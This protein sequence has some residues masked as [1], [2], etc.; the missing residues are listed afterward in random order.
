MVTSLGGQS[1]TTTQP[2]ANGATTTTTVA[3]TQ[4]GDGSTTQTTTTTTS[5]TGDVLA[6]ADVRS[7]PK[8]AKE[9]PFLY[10]QQEK[11]ILNMIRPAVR[12]MNRQIATPE[13]VVNQFVRV[14]EAYKMI[15]PDPAPKH[16][17]IQA[18]FYRALSL[19]QS[20]SKTVNLHQDIGLE[21]NPYKNEYLVVLS[22]ATKYL[23][24]KTALLQEDSQQQK[25]MYQD[26]DE[27]HKTLQEAIET[28]GVNEQEVSQ[29]EQLMEISDIELIIENIP[30]L[31]SKVFQYYQV[32]QAKENILR[33]E[34]SKN[35]VYQSIP[36]FDIM[37][38]QL[39]NKAL[40]AEDL[41]EFT[42]FLKL[43]LKE[44]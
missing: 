2:A 17:A 32:A 39:F 3:T 16:N 10:Q 36:S 1:S 23:N 42:K 41:S 40:E 8:A 31:F 43:S 44:L 13:E 18:M 19:F 5:T 15:R 6:L 20:D 37:L 12:T 21:T 9:V 29:I 26:L 7:N 34:D 22:Q 35:M 33:G 38:S 25:A 30:Y 4:N 24:D 11:D 27:F 28:A 14:K